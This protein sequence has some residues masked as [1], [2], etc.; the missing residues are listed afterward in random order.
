[1][2]TK[3]CTKCNTTK[4]LSE[5]YYIVKKEK[6]ET[7]CKE[8]ISIYRKK[9]R[10]TNK[11]KIQLASKIWIENNTEHKKELNKQY[12]ECN[13][14]KIKAYKRQYHLNNRIKI[15]E[16]TKKWYYEN[17]E[18]A[19]TTRNK[20]KKYYK[21]TE[22]YKA[23]NKATR[24][25]RREVLKNSEKATNTQIKQLIKE[26]KKCY[27]CNKELNNLYHIDHYMPIAK[28]GN[29]NIENLVISCPSCNLRKHSKDPLQF[30]KEIGK[31][32]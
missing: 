14:E 28:G 12:R 6:Y 3:L 19:K 13:I 24:I 30:A 31:I 27:W 16:K 11:E 26:S 20:Y 23:S 1:M 18:K 21:T 8:C 15:I 29:H 32:F 2:T 10:D 25:K 5:F 22:A 17:L 4:E 9:Y 7:H